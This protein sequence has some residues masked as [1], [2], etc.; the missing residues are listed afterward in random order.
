MWS[1]YASSLCQGDD[2]F[3][4]ENIDQDVDESEGLEGADGEKAMESDPV[5]KNENTG[6]VV[7]TTANY[8]PVEP[9]NDERGCST[10][11]FP[12]DEPAEE[13]QQEEVRTDSERTTDEQF[14]PRQGTPEEPVAEGQVEEQ[15]LER[16]E[17]T[18]EM[19]IAE[20]NEP[21]KET[22]VVASAELPQEW[23]YECWC[24]GGMSRLAVFSPLTPAI[25]C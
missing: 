3:T 4:D 12:K 21:K 16:E 19:A 14:T 20:N 9:E 23:P 22:I 24:E 10:T 6:D 1:C 25:L 17:I 13:Q 15:N 5:D 8:E 2:P 7:E 11:L 18:T